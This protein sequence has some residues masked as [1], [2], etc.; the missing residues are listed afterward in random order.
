MSYKYC[1]AHKRYADTLEW[2]YKRSPKATEETK[3]KAAKMVEDENYAAEQILEFAKNN[4][5]DRKWAR[6]QFVET[7]Q[8][9]KKHSNQTYT[10]TKDQET[11]MTRQAFHA[12]CKYREGLTESEEQEWWD[13]LYANPRIERD[14]KGFRGR[15][16]LHVPIGMLKERGNKKGVEE[17]F[18][19]RPKEM[20]NVSEAEAS[21][22]REFVQNSSTSIGDQFSTPSS[23]CTTS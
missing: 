1:E 8:Y 12:H 3:A 10:D 5:N 7:A 4:P 22:L 18:A 15:E 6:K 19:Q 21:T 13:E 14:N 16:Q 17:S 20:K 11:P 2:K 9:E 23:T